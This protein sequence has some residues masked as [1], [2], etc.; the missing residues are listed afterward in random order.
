MG[1]GVPRPGARV[2]LEAGRISTDS[3]KPLTPPSRPSA[4]FF[5]PRERGRGAPA[6][7]PPRAHATRAGAE[8]GGCPGGPLPTSAR[9]NPRDREEP[10]MGLRVNTNVFSLKAQ[11]NLATVS[12]RLGGNFSRLSS[13]LRIAQAADDAAGLGISERMRAQVRSLHQAGRNADDGISL[14]QTAEGS[15]NELNGNLVRMRELAIQSSNGTLNSGD[16]AILDSEFQALVSEI[17]RVSSQTTFN[18]VHLLDGSTSSLSIQVGT[19]S[20]ETIDVT[21]DDVTAAT[22]GVDTD[23]TDVTNAQAALDLIDTA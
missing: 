20:G 8:N 22:L 5:S 17:D 2:A 7:K 14:A 16:R 18:G 6:R 21:F 3:G 1:K 9:K 4:G 13:G 10:N 11:T 23:I 15:L 12:S 19:E